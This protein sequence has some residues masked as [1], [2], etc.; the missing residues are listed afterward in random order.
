M[1]R[2]LTLMR[3]VAADA[4]ELPLLQHAQ[5]LDLHGRGEVADLVQEERAAV[6]HLEAA[7]AGLATAPVKAPFS[8][9]NSS[10]SSSVSVRAAQLTLMNGPLARGLE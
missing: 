6:G 2:T 8:W 10:L 4:L 9:P 1:T 5:Q 3:L 7:L